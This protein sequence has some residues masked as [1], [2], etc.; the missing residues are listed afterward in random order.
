MQSKYRV[1]LIPWNKR[2]Y[3]DRA[4]CPMT[5]IWSYIVLYIDGLGWRPRSFGEDEFPFIGSQQYNIIPRTSIVRVKL[6]SGMF[7]STRVFQI[8]WLDSGGQEQSFEI[9]VGRP[10]AW[11]VA[12]EKIGISVI[13]ADLV[14]TKSIRGF[15]ANYALE[16]VLFWAFSAVVM[17]MFGTRN[18]YLG[19]AI[20]FVGII[21]IYYLGGML[22]SMIS[23]N[24]SLNKISKERR[25]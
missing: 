22:M 2:F 1:D 23:K 24:L 16:I 13:G 14:N 3:Q 17:F 19:L 20:S 15:I 18:L 21:V 10:H 5:G 12:F 9:N 7:W 6:K 4:Y 25:S 8:D 11:C